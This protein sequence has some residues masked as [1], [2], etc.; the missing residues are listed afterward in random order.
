MSLGILTLAGRK[1]HHMGSHLPPVLA[2]QEGHVVL[3]YVDCT[4]A[5]WAPEQMM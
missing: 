2:L 1:Q 3:E 5:E 4:G